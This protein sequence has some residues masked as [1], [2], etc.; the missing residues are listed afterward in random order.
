VDRFE[1]EP[2]HKHLDALIGRLLDNAGTARSALRSVLV[3]SWES[4]CQT[5]SKSTLNV[6]RER[7]GYD[8]RPW[9]PVLC[10]VTVGDRQ[11]SAR[12][13]WDI[14]QTLSEQMNGFAAAM[15]EWSNARGLKFAQEGYGGFSRDLVRYQRE[16]DV[17]MSETYNQFGVNGQK[18]AIPAIADFW[19]KP[20]VGLESF[21][22]DGACAL[23]FSHPGMF[24]G[25]GDSWICS[26]YNSITLHTYTHQPED[27]GPGAILLRFSTDFGRLQTWWEQTKPWFTHIDRV[28]SV[29]QRLPG[30][31]DILSVHQGD[32]F[33]R[34]SQEWATGMAEDVCDLDALAILKAKDGRVVGPTGKE[35]AVLTLGC[36]TTQLRPQVLRELKRLSD[37]GV[38][39][40]GAA[41]PTASPSLQ[42]YPRCDED[43]RQLATALW[44][45]GKIKPLAALAAALKERGVIPDLQTIPAKTGLGMIAWSHRRGG[46]V[47]AYFLSNPGRGMSPLANHPW[48]GEVKFRVTRKIPELWHPERGTIEPIMLYR[49]E[50]QQTIIPLQFKSQ[51]AYLIV[52]RDPTPADPSHLVSMTGPA[53][54]RITRSTGKTTLIASEAGAWKLTDAGGR[55]REVVV[56]ALPSSATIAGPWQ[57]RF[58]PG[59]G[60]PEKIDLPAL[61]DWIKHPDAGV[62][63]FSGTATYST[64]ISL[65]TEQIGGDLRYQLDLGEVQQIA[66]VRLNGRKLGLVYHA[67]FVLD[68]GDGLRAGANEL[69]IE[70]TNTWVN[71]LV[72]DRDL[73]A[74]KR[75]GYDPFDWA[76][77]WKKTKVPAGLIGPVNLRPYR[78]VGLD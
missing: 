24:K 61:V 35:Y 70:I 62:Q 14:R 26:G 21:V 58:Q 32:G 15:R 63:G 53:E 74:D 46:E 34:L 7:R 29:L 42:D 56:P 10:G 64:T 40:L 16:L 12:F 52:F 73:P 39:I 30:V 49:E 50:G 76:N 33:T 2:I 4:R 9:L 11:Q 31:A 22:G 67:P 38:T 20:A 1:R 75:I 23:R 41:K 45:S 57:V 8:P 66:E 44:D 43:V 65:K 27:R 55:S 68:A 17:P 5:W 78:Q 71:R 48:A 59:R 37:A 54:G 69:E 13:L 72:A 28:Q 6:F 25:I 36:D 77:R 60:A 47:D 19:G 3:D 51:E 18:Q